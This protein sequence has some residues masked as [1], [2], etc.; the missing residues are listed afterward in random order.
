MLSQPALS[1][2]PIDEL[3]TEITESFNDFAGDGFTPSPSTGQLNSNS[4]AVFGLGDG[5]LDFGGTETSGDFARG[6]DDG[7]VGTG[8]IYAFETSE[9]DFTLG[10]QPIGSDLTPGAIFMC[11]ENATGKPI[12]ELDV[13]YDLRYYNDQTRSNDLALF[14]TTS[15]LCET[16]EPGDVTST[17]TDTGVSFA[18]PEAEDP[19]P[20]WEE[21]PQT[22]TLIGLNAADGMFITLA[23][24]TDDVSG[25]G[26][27]PELALDDIRVEARA[28]G[29][30][31]ITVDDDGGAD[32]TTIQAAIDAASAGN[33]IEIAEGTYSGDLAIDKALTLQGV[34]GSA[35]G[36]TKMN[37][38]ST[39]TCSAGLP[40]V[41]ASGSSTGLTV[42]AD[43]VT[44]STLCITGAQTHNIYTD[45]TISDL[46]LDSVEA[47][48]AGNQGFEVHND[49]SVTTLAI[50]SSTFSGNNI[51]LRIRG[52]V[53]GLD[54]SDSHFD[55][56]IFG[57]ST[58]HGGDTS[59]STT[60]GAATIA[61]STFN[62]NPYKGIYV[63]KFEG[64]FDDIT[65]TNSGTD[66]TRNY[67]QAVDINLKYR[68]YSSVTV[69]NS[70]LESGNVIGA[71]GGGEAL[72]VKARNDGSYS[73]NPAT[74]DS[75]LVAS[76]TLN[77][78]RIGL[79]VGNN[80]QAAT[81]RENLIQNNDNASAPVVNGIRNSGGLLFY[82]NPA[83]GSYSVLNNCIT[84]NAAY[85]LAGAST[86][87]TVAASGN[88]WGA[89]SGP[90]GDFVGGGDA[91]FG[92]VT[93]DF[94]PQSVAACPSGDPTPN[95]TATTLSESLDNPE[96]GLGVITAT[97]S[98]PDGIEKI[99]FVDPDGDPFL[100]NLV[101][102]N[103]S[104]SFTSS[105]NGITWTPT[106]G[107]PQEA[108]FKLTQADSTVAAA[109]YFAEATSVCSN[110][111]S[112]VVDF[113][114]VHTLQVGVPDKLTL[115]GNYPNPFDRQTTIEFTLPEP[116]D[117]TLSVFDLMGR[118]V[119]TLVEGRRAAGV[120]QV[121]WQGRG[122]DDAL[123]ASGLYLVRLTAG[124]HIRTGRLTIVR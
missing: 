4:F 59:G 26:S 80:V 13:S 100:N 64:T 11:F 2:V 39:P 20:Q 37:P 115:G 22:T 109:S 28:A 117:V 15:S 121:Q 118:R 8:G 73:S 54:I 88:Y 87:A 84:G 102:S 78:S 38:K 83:G 89:G 77:N 82:A 53:S 55:G 42:G 116:A 17:F 65:V 45:T 9:N 10:F 51:G 81:I 56:N 41:D 18:V 62:D 3:D 32:F 25:S 76:N 31:T 124:Q 96:D 108:V 30:A 21:E 120:H 57:F 70:A 40:V 85:G 111:G 71:E 44:L 63:E 69:M 104:N 86:G 50:T 112:L 33:V 5:D 92:N 29:S 43:N 91:V 123:L 52:S 105:D 12:S 99:A 101:A 68:T 75:L 7:Q 67:P 16:A 14:Y 1:Q 60:V 93:V 97:F 58:T 61:S 122:A 107:T 114:P 19:N 23:F 98:N 36:S 103:P 74:L 72:I 113:D 35:T 46:T 110:P 106:S 34:S 24:V 27:R 48:N 79:S 119:A 49:A 94:S 47:L 90:S 6:S 95:C 66:G